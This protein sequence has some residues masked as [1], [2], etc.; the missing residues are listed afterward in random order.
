M[1][2]GLLPVEPFQ[3]GHFLFL[4]LEPLF[5]VSNPWQWQNR[6]DWTMETQKL[7][8]KMQCTDKHMKLND[9]N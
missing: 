2:L 7:T 3:A 6:Q 5:P 1:A 8:K 4:L 9:I